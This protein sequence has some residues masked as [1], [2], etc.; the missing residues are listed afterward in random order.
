MLLALL[1]LEKGNNI[2]M[3]NL[4]IK[5]PLRRNEHTILYILTSSPSESKFLFILEEFASHALDCRV[6][7]FCTRTYVVREEFLGDLVQVFRIAALVVNDV[8]ANKFL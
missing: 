3:Q 7:S 2:I 1:A 8:E 5:F 4:V 6:P